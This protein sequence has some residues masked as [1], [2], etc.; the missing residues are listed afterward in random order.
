MHLH[1][2]RIKVI[3]AGGGYAGLAA[4]ISLRQHCP[5]AEI[6]LLDPNAFHLRRTHLHESLRQN[7]ASLRIPFAHIIRRF[8]FRHVQAAL[9]FNRETL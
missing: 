9:E 7:S 1:S 5:N 8:Q 6:I 2:D 3:V 4:E